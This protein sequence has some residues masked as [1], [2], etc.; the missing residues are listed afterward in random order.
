MVKNRNRENVYDYKG[1][2][3]SEA[4]TIQSKHTGVNKLNCKCVQE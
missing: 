3:G 1:K 2:R 4:D